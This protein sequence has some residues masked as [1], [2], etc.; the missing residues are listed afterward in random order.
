MAACQIP[1]SLRTSFSQPSSGQINNRPSKP[2]VLK[3]TCSHAP[4]P[5]R[6]LRAAVIG[7]GPAGASAAEALAAGG[8]E[9]FLFE[10]NPSAAKPCGGAIP[11]CM[12]DEFSIPP[13]LID[14]RVTK[15]KIISPSNL[16]VDFGSKSLRPNEHIPMLRR[17]VLDSFLRSRAQSSGAQLITA[18]VTHLEVPSSPSSPYIIYHTVNNSRKT[19]AVD[20]VIGA[21]GANSKVAKSINAGELHLRHSVSGENPITRRENGILP[22][23]RGDDIKLYQRGIRER[24]KDKIDGGRVIKVEAHPIPEHPRAIRVRGRVALVGDAAGYVT[25]CSG[26][27]IYFA[28]K[29]G[30]MCGEAVVRASDG[31]DRMI[32]EDD[33]KREYLR[34]WDRKYVSTFRFLDLL[35]R[36][37]YRNNASREAL[38]ELCSDE[39][40]Q[41]MTFDSYLYKR[42]ADGDRWE[43]LKMAFNTVGSLMRC[44]ILGRKMQA[45]KL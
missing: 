22:K 6:K 30:R 5:G 18:L 43:D 35:Q 41:R 32:G 14:R 25:K 3:V 42:L 26:E 37:F 21:D 33:L 40:V 1:H 9:T 17:E 11:L 39:Y 15:M 19:L 31:G 29:S 36:V 13:H 27:G 8:I 12:L 7:G 28:A 16:A 24:A 34:E 10:R 44:E 4:L 45:L 2:R 23:S 38:V 20:V